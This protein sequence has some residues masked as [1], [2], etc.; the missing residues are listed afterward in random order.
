MR[1]TSYLPAI[2]SAC[3]SLSSD[4][5]VSNGSIFLWSSIIW[6]AKKTKGCTCGILKPYYFNYFEYEFSQFVS[7]K[8]LG[9][10]NLH[11][12]TILISLMSKL[13]VLDF[14]WFLVSSN[15][16]SSSVR[17]AKCVINFLQI[18]KVFN[19]NLSIIHCIPPLIFSNCVCVLLSLCFLRIAISSSWAK[20][21]NTD[22]KKTFC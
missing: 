14:I 3:V 22:R 16:S 2:F 17:N 20:T 10:K 9:G 5:S 19:L 13:F 4:I 15:S 11:K 18:K 6:A 8:R 7:D 21:L 12:L 1:W